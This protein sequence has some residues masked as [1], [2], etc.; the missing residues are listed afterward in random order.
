MKDKNMKSRGDFKDT[1]NNLKNQIAKHLQED[2]KLRESEKKYRVLVENLPQKIFHKD[3]N[4]VYLS[5]NKN[6]AHDL[7]ISPEQIIGKTDYDFY[8]KELAEKYRADDKRVMESG[9]VE[10]IEERYT[11]NGKEEI[12]QT[13]KAPIKN[14]LGNVI[15][16]LGIF[17]DITAHKQ[18]EENLKRSEERFH[19]LIENANDAIVSVN[20]KGVINGFNKKAEEMF[21]YSR[22]EVLGKSAYILISHRNEDFYKEALEHFAMTG[23][24]LVKGNNILE[25]KAVRKGG[26]EFQV[27]YSYYTVNVEGEYISTAIIRDITERKIKEKKFTEYQQKLRSLTSQLTLTEE[28]ERRNFSQYLHDEIGQNLFAFQLQLQQ[29]K[30]KLTSAENVESINNILNSLRQVINHS[31]SLTYALS[32]PILNELGLE[33]A[34]EWLA[35]ETHKEFNVVVGFLDDKKEKPLD[36]DMKIFLYQAVRELLNNVAKH[37][38]T[39]KAIVSIKKNNSCMEVCVEDRGVGFDPSRLDVFD[40]MKD[41]FGLFH[42]KERIEQFGGKIKIKSQPN[43]GTKITLTAPLQSPR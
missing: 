19:K 14:E 15:G 41:E 11:Q 5:C 36:D 39:E 31:R 10:T 7:K 40:T 12:V 43:R 18:A 9:A 35:E 8:S 33:K 3:K 22:E 34:L 2:E 17:W 28:R 21:K 20:A 25:G 13:V 4:S 30:N 24:S 38:K 23:A 1:A 27:E 42:I 32:P 16:V 29:V 26:E 6:Y 37:A